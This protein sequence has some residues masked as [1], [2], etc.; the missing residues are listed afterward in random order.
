LTRENGCKSYLAQIIRCNSKYQEPRTFD[1]DG[2]AK[3]W[4]TKREKEIDA[5]ISTGIAPKKLSANRVTLG[6]AIDRYVEEN[7]IAMGDTKTQVLSTI[8]EE[9]EIAGLRCDQMTSPD[10]V[11]FAKRLWDRP[12]INSGAT[13]SNFIEHLFSSVHRRIS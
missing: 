10:I 4:A 3:K 12:K 8:R 7:R 2:L 13:V 6:D 9:Y 11:A 5:D 1:K